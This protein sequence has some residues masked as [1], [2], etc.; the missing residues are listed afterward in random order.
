MSPTAPLRQFLEERE[1]HTLREGAALSSATRGRLQPEDE[2]P[3]RTAFQRDRDRII[4]TKAFRRLMRKTQVFLS[5][6]GDHHR[7]RLTHTLEVSQIARTAA[8]ALRLNEDLTEAIALSHDLG[9]PP[10]GHAGE[11]VLNEVAAGG[12]AHPDQSLRVVDKLEPRKGHR[13]LNL[14]FE[15]RDGI[16]CHSMAKQLLS[17]KRGQGAATL[18]G[19]LVSVCDAIAYIN[20]DIDDAVR[21]G[22]M[23]I[24]ELPRDIIAVLGRSSSER[25]NAMV[26]ALLE[27]S[28]DGPIDLTP[29]VRQATWELRAFLYKRLYPSPAVRREIDKAAKLLGE[30]CR[31]LLEHPTEASQAGDPRDS[32]E[33]R[34]IDFVAGMTDTYALDLYQR[35]FLPATWRS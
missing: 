30:L 14:T 31:H 8:R 26:S 7:T 16:R 13:G 9:H 21:A 34:T 20:H 33:R 35:I 27:A 18:E 22:V 5:P 23:G 28:A 29:D 32:L 17:G 4:H 2:H 15:V 11:T 19:D 6:D 10:F 25:I 3:Y 1:R 24:E 12:F